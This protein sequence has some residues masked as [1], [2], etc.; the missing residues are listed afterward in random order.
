[1]RD[2]FPKIRFAL[3]GFSGLLVLI[4]LTTFARD[5]AGGFYQH[6]TTITFSTDAPEH[7]T[8][9]Y[10]L[11]VL[12]ICL[13]LCLARKYW[14]S[15]L[16]TILYA[17]FHSYSVWVRSQGCFLGEDICP[18]VAFLEKVFARLFWLD[19]VVS[20]F[21]VTLFLLQIFAVWRNQRVASENL[22]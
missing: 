17:L 2:S 15:L 12:P 10:N 3:I 5:I 16:F 11:L 9:G 20:L 4:V 18:P 13:S 1:M 14:T 7:F 22:V 21:I 8:G 6:S 19:W